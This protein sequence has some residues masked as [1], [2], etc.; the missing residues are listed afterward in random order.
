[1]REKILFLAKVLVLSILFFI[2]WTQV[3]AIYTWLVATGATFLR[4]SFG[5]SAVKSV[6]AKSSYLLVAFASVI[7]AA[8]RLSLRQKLK[9]VAIGIF[10]LALFDILAVATEIV[11]VAE[12]YRSGASELS[13]PAGLLAISYHAFVLLLP[14]L[15][16]ILAVQGKVEN[17][18]ASPVMIASPGVCP[19]CGKERTGLID[20]IRSVHGEKALK[21]R[22]VRRQLARIK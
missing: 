14:F 1:V 21:K 2:L 7:L 6:E 9:W 15:L 17:L 16:L 5:A 11:R 13:F 19:I 4:N 10:S 22:H 12:Q 18:W 3:I 20:H 8:S